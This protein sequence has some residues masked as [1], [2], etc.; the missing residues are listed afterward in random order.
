MAV[1]ALQFR[2]LLRAVVLRLSEAEILLPIR[3]LALILESVLQ[4]NIETI[5][6]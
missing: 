6:K 2:K 4:Q 3:S 1:D 5:E